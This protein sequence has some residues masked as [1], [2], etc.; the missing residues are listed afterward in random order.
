ML[1]RKR[2]ELCALLTE[3]AAN[4]TEVFARV[5]GIVF[6]K[7]CVGSRKQRAGVRALEQRLTRLQIK[8]KV[9]VSVGNDSVL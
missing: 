6:V 1:Q 8:L 7:L 3:G 9:A 2:D 4:L 5:R